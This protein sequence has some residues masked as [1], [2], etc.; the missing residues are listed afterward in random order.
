M[1][2]EKIRLLILDLPL[3]SDAEII[4]RWLILFDGG[5]ETIPFNP[6]GFIIT[7]IIITPLLFYIFFYPMTRNS[8]TPYPLKREIRIPK[9]LD[10]VF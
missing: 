7:F 2:S 6:L 4:A 3:A 5:T 1:S 9:S 10:Y 8:K